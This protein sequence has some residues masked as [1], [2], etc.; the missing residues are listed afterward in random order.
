MKPN[1]SRIAFITLAIGTACLLGYLGLCL[2]DQSATLSM[3]R[4]HDQ[5]T[6]R[7]L[8]V[9]CTTMPDVFRIEG[10][11]TQ[12]NVLSILRK[13]MPETHIVTRRSTIEI[14]QI[15]FCF[16]SDGSLRRIDR[17]DDY[18]TAADSPPSNRPSIH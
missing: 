2:L 18:G 12:T 10:G 1:Q 14:D 11:T 3:L 9:L 4:D 13:R 6:E 16:D 5:R 8:S 7:A 15:R 17:T